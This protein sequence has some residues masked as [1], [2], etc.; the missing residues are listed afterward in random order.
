MPGGFT[1]WMSL[2]W[3]HRAI[4]QTKDYVRRSDSAFNEVHGMG[5]HI[6]SCVNI[7]SQDEA[8]VRNICINH[9]D[10]WRLDKL[11]CEVKSETCLDYLVLRREEQGHTINHLALNT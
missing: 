9:S 3:L 8:V 4:A 6:S 2:G 1:D 10:L 7:L 11:N 5:P